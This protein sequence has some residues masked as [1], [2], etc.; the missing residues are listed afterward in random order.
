MP[1]H[2]LTIER[3]QRSP[4]GVRVEPRV[5]LRRLPDRRPGAAIELRLPD[6]TVRVPVVGMFCV[7]T[8]TDGDHH[9]IATDPVNPELSL[10]IAGMDVADVPAGTEVW[11]P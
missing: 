5:L 1:T 7:D 4:V 2:L 10:T 11:L 3:V 6:G 9:F 8:G